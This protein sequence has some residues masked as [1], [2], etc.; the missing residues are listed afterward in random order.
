[1]LK[2]KFR[3][4]SELFEVDVSVVETIYSLSNLHKEHLKDF[5]YSEIQEEKKLFE[6]LNITNKLG[7]SIVSV[8]SRVSDY[9][10]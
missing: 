2:P 8:L 4:I 9:N 7:F 10:Q 3:L 1:M 6:K 5:T